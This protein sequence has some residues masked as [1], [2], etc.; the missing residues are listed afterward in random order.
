MKSTVMQ[1][2]GAVTRFSIAG[3]VTVAVMLAGCASTS[4]DSDCLDE[5]KA[6]KSATRSNI[7]AVLSVLARQQA[8]K[9]ARNAQELGS[10]SRAKQQSD[11][12]TQSVVLEEQAKQGWKDADKLRLAE[13]TECRIVRAVNTAKDRTDSMPTAFG[14]LAPT[15]VSRND[16]KGQAGMQDEIRKVYQL[17]ERV[18]NRC[19]VVVTIVT[20][21]HR[22]PP[23]EMNCS[24]RL[25]FP[26]LI[27]VN[28]GESILFFSWLPD[29]LGGDARTALASD[30]SSVTTFTKTQ[31][32]CLGYTRPWFT[33]RDVLPA[34]YR[35]IAP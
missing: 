31:T 14:C 13:R 22:C 15:R 11:L 25:D 34:Y 32:V 35:C 29:D 12:G 28:A 24:E 10:A 5:S 18:V 17:G 20:T 33:L 3:A 23:P 19:S 16:K 9:P 26:K 30:M 7:M 27:N 8:L 2:R 4:P 1:V 6:T 21:E